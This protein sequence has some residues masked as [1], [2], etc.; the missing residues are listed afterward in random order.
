VGP[1]ARTNVQGGKEEEKDPEAG[2]M[3]SGSMQSKRGTRVLQQ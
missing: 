3:A 2:G 1:G